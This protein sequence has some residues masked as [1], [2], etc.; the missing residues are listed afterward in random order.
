MQ[1]KWIIL[2]RDGVINHDSDDYIKT[3]DE[4]IPIPGSLEAIARL[5]WA[6]YYVLVVTNQSGVARKLYDEKTLDDIHNKMQ[7]A[8]IKVGGHLEGIFYCPHSPDEKCAC[9]KPKP[10]LYKAIIKELNIDLTDVPAIG[11]KWTDVQAA[12]AV[13]CQPI[14]VRTGRGEQT[15]AEHK[16]ALKKIPVYADLAE[17]VTAILEPK[18]PKV[19]AKKK[20]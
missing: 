12:R 13:G 3:P 18:S 5:N 4:W 6:G 17:A 2:D 14:L 20:S 10:G 9:R 16:V 7:D 1:K 15:L 19:D 11:D 8:L